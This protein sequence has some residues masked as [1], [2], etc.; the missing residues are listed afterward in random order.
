[1]KEIRNIFWDYALIIFSQLLSFPFSF[2]YTLISAKLMGATGYGIFNLFMAIY[3]LVFFMGFNWLTNSTVRFAKEEFVRVGNMRKTFTAKLLIV[4]SCFCIVYPIL[5]L[6]KSRILSYTTLNESSFWLLPALLLIYMLADQCVN[7]LQSIGRMKH[8]A[9][10]IAFRQLMLLIMVLCAV[11]KVIPNRVSVF[12]GFEIISYIAVIMFSLIFIKVKCIFPLKYDFEQFKK[13]IQYS[14]PLI[15]AFTAAYVSSWVNVY[16]IKYFL[17]VTEVGIYQ[18]GYKIAFYFSNIIMGVTT[19]TFPLFVSLRSQDKEKVLFNALERIIPQLSF[20]WA[21]FISVVIVGSEV[22]FKPVFSNAYVDSAL[23]FQIIL[24]GISF[25]AISAVST[26]VLCAFDYLKYELINSIA[27]AVVSLSVSMFL[28]PFLGIMGAAIAILMS[29]LLNSVF[30]IYVV[31]K[32]SRIRLY[33]ALFGPLF[34]AAVLFAVLSI[35]NNLMHLLI[36]PFILL[37]FFLWG[38]KKKI[39]AKS[40]LFLLE[41]INIPLVIRSKLNQIYYLFD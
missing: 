21:L 12:I 17:S 34:C 8:Y 13:I 14:W 29:S 41:K 25:H 20:F 2:F 37:F 9:F 6:F 24:A 10:S 18:F 31:A 27:V 5:Y 28:V 19:L 30:Y 33:G 36:L 22:I 39:F 38:R 32:I 16:I 26:S 11:L 40:D 4:I 23:I 35:K 7:I 15:L 3:Q 1:M